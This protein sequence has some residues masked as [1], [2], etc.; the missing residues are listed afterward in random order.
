VKDPWV[1]DAVYKSVSHWKVNTVMLEKL[2]VIHDNVPV[3]DWED[4]LNDFD[5]DDD[6]F[7]ENGMF[8]CND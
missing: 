5:Q 7:D 3:E 2:Q 8:I 6:V 4:S 1:Y